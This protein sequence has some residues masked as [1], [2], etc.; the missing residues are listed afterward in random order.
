MAVNEEQLAK[1]LNQIYPLVAAELQ[2]GVTNVFE[3]SAGNSS[4]LEEPTIYAV[5]T[6]HLVADGQLTDHVRNV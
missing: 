2:A 3:I 6:V 5:Q 4:S 1:W